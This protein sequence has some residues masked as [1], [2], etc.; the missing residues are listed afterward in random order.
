[1]NWKVV[2]D[3]NTVFRPAKRGLLSHIRRFLNGF[4][5]LG[6]LLL[7]ILWSASLGSAQAGKGGEGKGKN[8][9]EGVW[10]LESGTYT[11]PSETIKRTASDFQSIKVITGSY[12][13]VLQ[14]E[15]IRAKFVEGGSDA[16]VLAAA[17]SF[18]GGGGRYTVDGDTYTEHIEFSQNP[19]WVGQSIQFKYEMQGPNRWIQSGTFPLKKMGLAEDDTEFVEVWKRIE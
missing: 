3:G 15:P 14:Q 10:Q 4:K 1:M 16:E 17:K 13:V 8:E 7:V 6:I 5:G 2:M 12:W 19:N 11:N 9:L 18:H